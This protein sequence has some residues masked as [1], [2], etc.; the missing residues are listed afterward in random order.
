MTSHDAPGISWTDPK[1]A[2]WRAAPRFI[3]AGYGI[4]RIRLPGQKGDGQDAERARL[5]REYQRE[6][7]RWLDALDKPKLKLGSWKHL[8]ARY[9]TDEFSPLNE[10]KANTRRGYLESC[11]YWE[12][13][14][15]DLKVSETDYEEVKR[16]ER[17]ML[18]NGKSADHVHRV[19]TQMRRLASYGRQIKF[20]GA[21]DLVEVLS[22]IRFKLP[23]PR[24]VAPTR[25]Q[26]MQIVSKADEEGMFAFATGLLI[27][28]E[29]TL[30]G[31]D[32]FGQWFDDDG[33][34]GGIVHEGKRWQDGLTWDMVEP[35]FGGFSKVISKTARSMPDP[36]RFDL[37]DLPEIRS[38]LRLLANGGR[39]GPVIVTERFRRPYRLDSRSQAWRRL[40]DAL[41][42][43]KNIWMMDTRAGAVTE[44]KRLGA[45]PMALRDAA[46]HA[47]LSTTSRYM[48]DRS[49]GVAKVVKLRREGEA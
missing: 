27:Q 7:E 36:I 46:Q 2:F 17:A 1:R 10:V 16:L 21:R 25:A 5:C 14:I 28:F 6:A 47:N 30:R 41:K 38:R 48:R 49:E 42:L 40:R 11:V 39:V 34:S 45:D 23:P 8:I 37:T 19:F 4:K 44:A 43:P 18:Q 29:L 32:V 26:I 31:V 22:D 9:R 35:D 3:R 24:N 20:E 33:K 13:V 15:G 12:G